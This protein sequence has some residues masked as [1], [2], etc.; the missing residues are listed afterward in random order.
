ML[1]HGNGV[2]EPT[3]A[4]GHAGGE[5]DGG[6]ELEEERALVL[7]QAVLDDLAVG[8]PVLDLQRLAVLPA[9]AAGGPPADA[10]AGP[11]AQPTDCSPSGAKASINVVNRV[12]PSAPV[13]VG[14]FG[15]CGSHNTAFVP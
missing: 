2:T 9:R 3:A 7:R 14:R 13:P 4:P 10:P 12:G 1:H 6:R 8:Q 5:R 15:K 11:D